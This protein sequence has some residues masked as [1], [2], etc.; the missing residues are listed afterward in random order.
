MAQ[1]NKSYED[2]I[3]TT[4][5]AHEISALFEIVS[6][7][8]GVENDEEDEV[9]HSDQNG[10]SVNAYA[11]PLEL[12][13]LKTKRI[14]RTQQGKRSLWSHIKWGV[15]QSVANDEGLV[16]ERPQNA[17]V[18]DRHPFL[19]S[20]FDMVVTN[21]D[22]TWAPLI[23]KNVP[24]HMANFWRN[25]LGNWTVPEAV[26]L[27]AQQHM[28]VTNTKMCHVIGFFAGTTARHFLVER[29]DDLIA[30]IEETAESFWENVTTDKQPQ[31]SGHKDAAILA[32]L[33]AKILDNPQIVDWRRNNEIQSLL[34]EQEKLQSDNK[35]INKRL[36]EIKGELFAKMDG[37]DA[38]IIEDGKQLKWIRTK[39]SEV[40]YVKK[41]SAH[42]RKTNIKS[43]V[44][45]PVLV[46]KE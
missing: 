2:L 18:H 40:S 27:E 9:E 6:E 7:K 43:E 10:D 37:F 15:I 38:A 36:D 12:W 32:Q 5:S 8:L 21:E 35:R 45:G 22:G 19:S 24:S 44:A 39:E 3:E 16:I 25:A 23:A 20:R 11:S 13:A 46:D 42:L 28:S 1:T 30:D 29:D 26:E 4:I 17:Y 31:A 33:N 14:R 34:G 41:T